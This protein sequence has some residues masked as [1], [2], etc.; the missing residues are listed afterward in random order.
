MIQVKLKKLLNKPKLDSLLDNFTQT[1]NLS[2]CI[3]DI[4]GN[5][6]WGQFKNN[7]NYHYPI[8]VN[9]QILG[10]I[11]GDTEEIETISQMLNYILNEEFEKKLLAVDTLEK[12][13]ELNFLSD[14]SHQLSSCL[15]FEE[16][17]EVVTKET[18]KVITNSQIYV[19]LLDDKGELNIYSYQ[20]KK[21]HKRQGSIESI[22][23]HVLR[24]GKAEIV[25][26]V[27]EDSRYIPQDTKVK[28]LICAPLKV[29]NKTIG[30][31]KVTH[32]NLIKYTSEQLKLLASLT[33]QAAI[34]IQ[35]T[36][37]YNKLIDYSQTLE[38]KVEERTEALEEAKKKLEY[39]ATVDE[40]TQVYNRRYFNEYFEREWRRLARERKFI[41]LILCDVDY[42]K[43]YNDYYYHQAGDECLHEVAQCLKNLVKRPADLVARFGGEEFAIILSSTNRL[44]AEKVAKQL[45]QAIEGLEIPHCCSE[46]SSYVTLSLGVAIT[47]PTPQVSPQKLIKAAD[48]ALYQ[49]K[50]MGRNCFS[51]CE[52]RPESL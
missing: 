29:Q 31:I 51:V 4:E 49:A 40:L 17:M 5:I 45:C 33:S 9:Q 24:S 13:E 8:L 23:G 12:Y 36:Q 10:K 25:N 43:R 18:N 47:I 28:S 30:V 3:S 2:F 42:F 48:K 21:L 16:I 37:H 41:S 22:T 20:G 15:S 19:I 50:D 26:D 44:G 35:N 11:N 39:L 46:C 7:Y 27:H 14:I 6:I 34:A 1:F 38:Q 52:F 32:N